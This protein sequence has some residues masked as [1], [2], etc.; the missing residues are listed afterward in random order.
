MYQ[1]TTETIIN[2]NLDSNGVLAKYSG[3]NNIFSVSRVGNFKSNEVLSCFKNAYVDPVKEKIVKTITTV[4]TASKV[5]RLSIKLKRVNSYVSEYANDMSY[6]ALQ[7]YYEITGVSTAA[8]LVTAFVSLIN[9][10]AKLKDIVY[11]TPTDG[12]SAAL[13]LEVVDEYTRFIEVLI[14]EVSSVSLTGYDTYTTLEDVLAT[15]TLTVG[16]EGFG[17]VKQITKN[18]R[19]PTLANTNWTAINQEEKPVAGGQYTQY[20]LKIKTNRGSMGMN[21]VGQEVSSVTDHIF[22]V[23]ST[24]VSGFETALTNAG[25]SI[26]SAVPGANA[27]SL[28]YVDSTIAVGDNSTPTIVG[29]NGAVTFTSATTATATVNATTGVI[30]AVAAGTSVI[31]ATDSVGSTATFTITVIA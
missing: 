15:G 5:Y 2:S 25:I 9:K 12:G 8:G 7:K 24:L 29:A 20:S 14:Q 28:T 4:P 26:V 21:V 27:F 11:V 3:A 22:Y 23:L 16:K 31:T 18:L 1:F 10:E 30:T 6:N 13:T 17:T 19:L